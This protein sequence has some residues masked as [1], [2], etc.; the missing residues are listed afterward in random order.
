M[1][2]TPLGKFLVSN[3]FWYNSP[4]S[5]NVQKNDPKQFQFHSSTRKFDWDQQS[6]LF[7]LGSMPGPQGPANIRKSPAAFSKCEANLKL[8]LGM[9]HH[10]KH[11]SSWFLLPRLE[12]IKSGCFEEDDTNRAHSPKGRKTR[13]NKMFKSSELQNSKQV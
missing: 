12:W 3:S 5:K 1:K 4:N 7:H 9:L 6:D 2:R 11:T 10:R 13:V 8:T